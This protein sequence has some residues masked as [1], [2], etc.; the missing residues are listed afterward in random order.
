M[1]LGNFLAKEEEES[2][3]AARLKRGAATN[4]FGQEGDERPQFLL[5]TA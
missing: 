4:Y 5:K 3:D 1:D 2:S